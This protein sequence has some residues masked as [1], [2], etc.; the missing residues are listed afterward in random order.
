M[1]DENV[2]SDTNTSIRNVSNSADFAGCWN[3]Y[4][5]VHTS[6]HNLIHVIY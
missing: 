2:C 5:Q 1:W 3:G 4:R 6:M